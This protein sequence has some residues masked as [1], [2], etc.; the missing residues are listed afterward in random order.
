MTTHSVADRSGFV[1]ELLLHTSTAE[2]VELVG[3]LCRRR[4]TRPPLAHR[5]RGAVVVVGFDEVGRVLGDV[6]AQVGGAAGRR[7]GRRPL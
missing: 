3:M 2:M 4:A 5:P 1:H 7:R 6:A